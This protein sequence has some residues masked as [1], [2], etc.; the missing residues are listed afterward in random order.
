MKT[1][2]TPDMYPGYGIASVKQANG[3]SI[4]IH[5]STSYPKLATFII[6]TADR[7]L[8]P[9]PKSNGKELMGAGNMIRFRINGPPKVCGY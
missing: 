1:A 8:G 5:V 7:N 3:R 2:E 6:E 4:R 9:N